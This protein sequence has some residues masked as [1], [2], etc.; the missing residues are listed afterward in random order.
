MF[1]LLVKNKTYIATL[2]TFLFLA[3]FFAV[4]ANGL[5]V[6]FGGSEISFVNPNCKKENYK[7]EIKKSADFSKSNYLASEVIDLNIICTSQFQF[8]LFNWETNYPKHTIVFNKHFTS[9]LT[10]LY[11]ENSSPPPRLT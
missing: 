10:F 2:L 11:L 3:K 5:N 1:V 6:L 8:E 4:D 9:K 7:K